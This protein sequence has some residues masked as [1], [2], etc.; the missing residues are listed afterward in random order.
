LK[1][2]G[3]IHFAVHQNLL[4]IVCM[5]LQRMGG[6]AC[7]VNMWA[8][9]L[10]DTVTQ[11]ISGGGSE[12]VFEMEEAARKE[13]ITLNNCYITRKV[14]SILKK[15]ESILFENIAF[16]LQ[17][18]DKTH[19]NR[20]REMLVQVLNQETQ[21]QIAVNQSNQQ[22]W[23]EY[24]IESLECDESLKLPSTPPQSQPLSALQQ[25]HNSDM[26]LSTIHEDCSYASNLPVVPPYLPPLNTNFRKYTLVLDLDETLIHYVEATFDDE[27]SAQCS[28]TQSAG[29]FLIRPGAHRFLREMARYFEIVIFTAAMQDVRSAALN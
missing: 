27:L 12:A 22:S 7:D 15:G 11:K 1:K 26:H 28:P 19:I 6:G 21:Q 29:Q 23:Q 24:P 10:K 2:L 20:V 4:H 16:F 14:K 25:H 18:I 8:V 17:E 3:R 5:I 9:A 13:L